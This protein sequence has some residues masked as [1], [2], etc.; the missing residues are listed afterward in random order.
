VLVRFRRL[1]Y[2][3]N[4][5]YLYLNVKSANNQRFFNVI[6]LSTSS[7]FQRRRSFNV[8]VLSTSFWVSNYWPVITTS[9]TATHGHCQS[10][11]LLSCRECQLLMDEGRA[12]WD[13][14][15]KGQGSHGPP[16]LIS[17]SSPCGC[18]I[19]VLQIGSTVSPIFSSAEVD[20]LHV[21]YYRVSGK[22]VCE[23]GQSSNYW[24]YYWHTTDQIITRN[25]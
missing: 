18:V 22:V 7:F 15:G 24:T 14:P 2:V 19:I 11:A 9:A 20:L 1:F 3:L 5:D 13:T 25:P 4:L 8:V 10:K 23:K 12:P 16:S 17:Q 6:V 21:R